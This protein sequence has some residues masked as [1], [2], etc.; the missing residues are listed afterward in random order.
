MKLK[1]KDTLSLCLLGLLLILG[2]QSQGKQGS[3]G[4]LPPS[5]V[6]F[7]LGTSARGIP[8]RIIDNN[9]YL[10]IRINDSVEVE[11]AFDSGLPI[12]GVIV[13]DSA[14][15][16]KLALSF[17]GSTPLGGAGDEALV[18]D[19]ALGGKISLS[20]V[21]FMDQQVLVVR[22]TQKYKKWLTGAI[23]GGTVLNSCVVQIDYEKSLLHIYED[24]TCDIHRASLLS[25]QGSDRREN[26]P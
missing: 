20:G 19:I 24:G 16:S 15:A 7:E 13:I 8:F 12:N 11:A 23:I 22:N 2:P 25:M 14:V 9:I 21:S 3:P 5:Q 1:V 17:V 18:A 4:P 10:T 6:H 26:R